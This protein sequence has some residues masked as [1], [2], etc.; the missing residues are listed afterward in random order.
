MKTYDCIKILKKTD[1]WKVLYG[2]AVV[3]SVIRQ[4][5][6]SCQIHLSSHFALSLPMSQLTDPSQLVLHIW[7]GKWNLPSIDPSCLAAV[8][9]LQLAIPGQFHISECTNPD[10]FHNGQCSSHVHHT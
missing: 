4:T 3:F 9:Y 10:L 6:F 5:D 8:L 1:L 7:P 2:L